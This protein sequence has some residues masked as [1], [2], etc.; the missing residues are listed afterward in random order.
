LISSQDLSN[1]TTRVFVQLLVIS[2]DYDR[3]ID[4][5][6]NGELMRLLEQAAFAL[7][8]GSVETLASM[9]WPGSEAEHTLIDFC[10]P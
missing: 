9:P 2:K 6:E 7:E 3:D 1:I 10:R 8:E 4:R 5:A